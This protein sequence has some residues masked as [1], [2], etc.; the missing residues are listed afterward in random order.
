[1]INSI[2]NQKGIVLFVTLMLLVLGFALVAT[3]FR[4]ASQDTKLASLEQG[5]T[6]AL[7]A[8]KAGADL[9]I[10]MAQN[11]PAATPLGASPNGGN[12][13]QVK[14]STATA[15]WSKAPGWAG[16]T[17]QAN[18]TN[19]DPTQFWDIT[20]AL[21]N[22]TVYV[23]VLD[24]STTTALGITGAPCYDGCFYYTVATSAQSSGSPPVRADVLFVYRYDQ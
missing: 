5:D 23:K 2:K 18:A 19:P 22:Y 9:F 17:T 10:Y 24:N 20:F 11:A 6:V 21:S 13:L 12:C 15:D 14:L 8:A 4:L 1:M 7:D 16:C 3:M